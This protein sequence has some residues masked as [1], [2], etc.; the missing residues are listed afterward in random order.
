MNGN[1]MQSDTR[2][3]ASTRLASLR[4]FL[5]AEP[6][7]ARLRRDLVDTAVAAG[8][9]EYLRGFAESRLAAD[10]G[11]AEAQYDRASALIG[12]K[13]YATALEALRP[14]D[15]TIPGVR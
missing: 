14:L 3:A 1:P 4:R 7:N 6:D 2:T 5:A 13:D 11:N 12:L 10:P 15:A 9:F 8:E